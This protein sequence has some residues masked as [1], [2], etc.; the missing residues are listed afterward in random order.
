MGT[1]FSSIKK[2]NS[3]LRYSKFRMHKKLFSTNKFSVV[4]AVAENSL[5]HHFMV[6]ENLEIE[7]PG[8]RQ[9]KLF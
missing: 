1:K 2:E 7:I 6:C 3:F 8:N 5:R 4:I 9:F